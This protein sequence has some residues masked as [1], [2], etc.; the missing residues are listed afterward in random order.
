MYGGS[1]YKLKYNEYL[2]KKLFIHK[3]N[4]NYRNLRL[5]NIGKYSISNNFDNKQVLNIIKDTIKPLNTNDLIITDANGNVGGDTILFGMNF[6]KVNSIE[7][8]SLHCEIL[9]NNINV[10]DLKNINIICDD[11]IKIK[12]NLKQDIIYFDPPWGGPDYKYKKTIDLFLSKINIIDITNKLINSTKYIVIKVPKNYN[13]KNLKK[14][15]KFKYIIKYEIIRY[16][17]IIL[18]N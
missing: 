17:I 7:I 10:Y 9:K 15:S 13:F 2:W 5:T 4:I 6:K 16:N 11:Y 18:Y 12:D 8:D 3:P 14:K 1:A